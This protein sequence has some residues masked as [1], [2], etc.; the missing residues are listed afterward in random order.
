[1]VT[2]VGRSYSEPWRRRQQRE[3][4]GTGFLVRWGGGGGAGSTTADPSSSSSSSSSVRIVTNAHV[5]R[6][7]S[8]VRARASFGPHVVNCE[9]EWLS[10]PLDLALLRI[11]EADWDDFRRGWGVG[12]NGNGGG[13]VAPPPVAVGGG[14]GTPYAAEAPGA[15]GDAGVAAVA[16]GDGAGQS[17]AP[18]PHGD[19]PAPPVDAASIPTLPPSLPP[20]LFDPSSICLT[21]SPGLPRLDEN[22]TCVGFPTGGTQISVTRGVVS[23]IDVDSHSVLRMQ[24]DAAIN[25]GNSGGPVFDERGHVVGVA[26]AHLR[27]ASNIG[28][29]IPSKIVGVFLDMCAEGMEAG[30]EDRYCGLG[31]LV[32]AVERESH[33]AWAEP[34][35]VPGIPNL[36]T[37]GSQ[38]LESKALRRH[39]GLA[40]LDIDGGIRIVGGA[41]GRRGIAVVG[42]QRAGRKEEDDDD[43]EDGGGDGDGGGGLRGDDVLLAID[44]CPIGMDFSNLI[45]DMC[46]MP[47]GSC[48]LL[49]AC[50]HNPT[51][52]NRA[53]DP[54]GLLQQEFPLFDGELTGR[55]IAGKQ[56]RSQ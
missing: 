2:S 33:G 28:Y 31:S 5:V 27:S 48:I 34:R 22:V 18:P 20:P 11:A 40:E 51:Y 50:A 10:L 42:E 44:G 16:G 49:H 36:A 19:G 55:H 6:N 37:A 41:S 21:L 14:G 15:G 47:E 46:A 8:T 17:P 25:P 56:P 32:D 1:M 38:S 4:S 29:I 24:I 35:H 26:S 13:G 23:R 3:G 43:G 53:E 39:L 52:A 9:V 30:V 45:E 54:D 12:G 7:A